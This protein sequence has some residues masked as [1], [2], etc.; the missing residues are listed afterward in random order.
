[1]DKDSKIFVAGHKGLVGSAI[2]R[3][4]KE[5]GYTNILTVDKSYIDLRN[6]E[7]T[8]RYFEYY[9]P[10]YVFLAAAKVG[11]ILHNQA[12]P[13]EFAFDNIMIQ[14]NV[15]ES[16]YHNDC[17]K[18][19]FLGSSCIYPKFAPQ[20]IKEEAL[21][22]SPLEPSNE[23]YAIAKIAGLKMCE[24]YRKQY[25]FDAISA[26]PTNLY[27]I[28]DNFHPNNSHVIPGLINR[29]YHAKMNA[30]SEVVCWGDGSPLREFLYVD[31]LADACLFL[32]NNY[33]SSQHINVGSTEE[34]SIRWI[35]NTIKELV[36]FTG[37]ITWDKSKPNGTPRKKLDVTKLSSLGWKAKMPLNEGL[38]NTIE[39]YKEKL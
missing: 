13:A 35:A 19:L 32:M 4:L 6:Q 9:K 39:W 31:D 1:M 8:Y 29:F 10:E 28:N 23:A 27:G 38:K 37:D 14:T 24:Y 2:V 16:A 15:I 26:M 22:T 21:L 36:G 20:P 34:V 25:Q 12:A 30:A 18:L 7:L 17:K 33:S 3:R 5:E 11:G